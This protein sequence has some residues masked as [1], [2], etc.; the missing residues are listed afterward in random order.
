MISNCANPHCH[1]PL[2]YLRNGKLYKFEAKPPARST[3]FFWLCGH[4][5]A[6]F[7]LA[8]EPAQGVRLVPRPPAAAVAVATARLNADP[9]V[10]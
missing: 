7:S 2:L 3:I 5:S 4:C 10:A 9:E 6:R 8:F 1:V